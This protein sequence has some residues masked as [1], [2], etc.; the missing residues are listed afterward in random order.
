MGA[1]K[2]CYP[3]RETSFE[4]QN[5]SML[6]IQEDDLVHTE[7][8]EPVPRPIVISNLQLGSRLIT[9]TRLNSLRKPFLG[10]SSH[11]NLGGRRI[12]LSREG[13]DRQVI[14]EAEVRR[15]AS[16]YGLEIIESHA[17]SVEDQ[18][19]PFR[20]ASLILAPHG[21]ALTNLIWCSPGTPVIELFSRSYLSHLFLLHQPPFRFA[22]HLPRR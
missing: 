4:S 19:S 14:N 22:T 21:S 7:Y 17:V 10:E 20:E 2:V 18:I 16:S 6:G 1:A 11:P 12:Y 13:L 8:I 15:I 9:P 5:L 3:L